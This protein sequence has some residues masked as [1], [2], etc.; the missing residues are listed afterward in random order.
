MNGS[1][2]ALA[3]STH[4]NIIQSPKSTA[5][6]IWAIFL[7]SDIGRCPSL[8]HRSQRCLQSFIHS[9]CPGHHLADAGLWIIMALCIGNDGISKGIGNDEHDVTPELSISC[10]IT[11]W[12]VYSSLTRILHLTW[13]LSQSNPY[14]CRFI[15][16]NEVTRLLIV[17]ADTWDGYWYNLLKS[18][19]LFL[20]YLSPCNHPP[21]N[22]ET[23]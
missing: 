2:P 10:D 5:N 23:Y 17:H 20:S 9:T 19:Y 8:Q 1:I 6:L 13:I 15:P 3:L 12:D 14:Q 18:M 7:I 4:L 22:Q 11:R 21:P 16:R